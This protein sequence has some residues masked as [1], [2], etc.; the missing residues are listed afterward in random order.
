MASIRKEECEAFLRE[1]L[2][3]ERLAMSVV[4]AGGSRD[5]QDEGGEEA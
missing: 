4:T 2:R 1:T 5:A 3:P